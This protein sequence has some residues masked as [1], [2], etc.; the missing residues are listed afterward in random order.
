MDNLHQYSATVSWTEERSTP[1]GTVLSR[2]SKQES[3]SGQIMIP[4]GRDVYDFVRVHILCSRPF[5]NGDTH[6]VNVH[7]V[8]RVG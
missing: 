2:E 3:R 7:S 5:T 4:Q 1:A 8:T 6:R